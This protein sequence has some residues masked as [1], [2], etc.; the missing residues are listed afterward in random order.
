MK[1]AIFLLLLLPLVTQGQETLNLTDS[2]GKKQGHWEKHYPNGKLMYEGYFK[3]DK[4]AGQWK[5]WQ[6]NGELKAVLDH[7]NTGDTINARLYGSGNVL[8]AEGKY[9][10]EHKEGIWKYYANGIKIAEENFENGMKNGLCRKFYATGE[11]L[12]SSEWVKDKL[13]GAYRAF[14]PG[15]KPYLQCKYENN[16]R[17][18]ICM[19]YYASG[20][21]EIESHYINNLPDGSWKYFDKDGNMKYLLLYSRGDLQNPEV[22][23]NLDSVQLNELEKKRN[24][25]ADP[26]KYLSNPEEYPER[27]H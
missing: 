5:R 11:L 12:E 8:I 13:Q 22:L 24:N 20:I 19:S 1:Q 6:D 9:L 4:P 21:V 10:V 25:L 2:S 23:R 26:E 17:N 27:K 16:A 18:G 14:F 3:N 15:G 7:G